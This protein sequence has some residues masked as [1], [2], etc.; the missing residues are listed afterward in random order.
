MT[1]QLCVYAVAQ[2]EVTQVLVVLTIDWVDKPRKELLRKSEWK[3]EKEKWSFCEL[4]ESTK[5]P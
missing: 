5:G 3:M 1:T 2:A 4:L